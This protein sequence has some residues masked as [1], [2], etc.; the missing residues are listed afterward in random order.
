VQL[1]KLPHHGSRQNITD[2]LLDLIDPEQ[3]LICTDGS[4]Y[5][6]PDEDALEKVRSTYPNVPIHFTDSTD[7]IRKRAHHVDM[8]APASTPV[9]IAL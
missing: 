3:I 5:G 8:Q 2:Q 1:L 4:Q 7:L 6:H 9:V